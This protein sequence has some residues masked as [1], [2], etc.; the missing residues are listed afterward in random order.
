MRNLV[1]SV[2]ALA[3]AVAFMSNVQACPHVRT[4]AIS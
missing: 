3:V 4:K 1:I 2:L